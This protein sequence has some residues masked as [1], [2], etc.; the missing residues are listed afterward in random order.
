MTTRTLAVVLLFAVSGCERLLSLGD[1]SR[2]Q[3]GPCV[4]EGCEADDAGAVCA[5]TICQLACRDGFERDDAGC[6]RCA[7]A[8]VDAGVPFDAGADAG[9]SD[10]AGVDAGTTS[11][12]G[13]G[14]DAGVDAGTVDA[15]GGFDAGCGD[16]TDCQLACQ[17]GFARDILGCEVCSCAAP[18]SDAGCG[19]SFCQMPCAFGFK[20][21]SS[22]CG[23]CE[24]SPRPGATCMPPPCSLS[25]PAGFKQ[26]AT[27]CNLCECSN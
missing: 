20:R 24:C 4:G 9:A 22:G 26:D 10:D 6:E 18:R 7:C 19:T 25:C 27:G 17:H 3:L 15:G 13:A 5:P 2:A 14:G 16:V 11:D 23:L 8:V 12:A 1:D 21:T